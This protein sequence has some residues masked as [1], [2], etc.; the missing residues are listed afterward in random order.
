MGIHYFSY[1][2]KIQIYVLSRN[3]KYQIFLSEYFPFQVLKFSIYL[4]RR[5]LIMSREKVITTAHSPPGIKKGI[6]YLI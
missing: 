5:V 3:E 1:F 4:N 6:D 2:A